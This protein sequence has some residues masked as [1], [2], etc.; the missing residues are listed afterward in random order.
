MPQANVIHNTEHLQDIIHELQAG[1]GV[2]MHLG[3][4]SNPNM[5]EPEE[6]SFVASAMHA[7]LNR[8]Q[9]ELPLS[10]REP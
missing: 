8:L 1:I 10:E 6:V 9:S 4:S 3:A 5:I 2:L 7:A